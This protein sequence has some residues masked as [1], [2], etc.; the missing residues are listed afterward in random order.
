MEQQ[1]Y[2]GGYGSYNPGDY[3][4]PQDG[5][6]DTQTTVIREDG[7][8]SRQETVI[9]TGTYATVHYSSRE[10]IDVVC[11]CIDEYGGQ[12]I[13]ERKDGWFDNDVEGKPT[14]IYTSWHR[15][16]LLNPLQSV[17]THI[18]PNGNTT[19]VSLTRFVLQMNLE[20][21]ISDILGGVRWRQQRLLWLI[22]FT[23]DR[24]SS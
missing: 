14:Y 15:W 1:P 17:V 22:S 24:H 7:F 11:A 12:T 21:L 23:R 5:G 19:Y 4:Q 16:N 9:T 2:G 3:Q 10:S 18:D 8:F 6:G 20:K 13:T